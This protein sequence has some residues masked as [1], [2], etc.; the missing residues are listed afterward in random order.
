MEHSHK[1]NVMMINGIARRKNSLHHGVKSL[2]KRIQD[3]LNEKY[4]YETDDI[5]YCLHSGLVQP[6]G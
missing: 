5:Y 4:Y 1:A 2:H 6:F 3:I